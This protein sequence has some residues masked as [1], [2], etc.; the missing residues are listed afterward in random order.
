MMSRFVEGDSVRIDI[1]DE[2]DVDHKKY[3][4]ERGEVEAILSDDA[5]VL[6]TDKRD[7]H[8]YRVALETGE[9][10]DFRWRDL[11]PSSDDTTQSENK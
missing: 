8:L 2:T 1:P 4:G 11:R 9:T 5:G 10:V 7:S 6:T 3:H